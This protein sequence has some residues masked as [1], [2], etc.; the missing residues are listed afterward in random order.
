MARKDASFRLEKKHFDL[1]KTAK[2]GL[3]HL[4]ESHDQAVGVA[5]Y[6]QQPGRQPVNLT[7]GMEAARLTR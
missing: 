4:Y 3:L 1:K 2:G 7:I 5:F 6:D